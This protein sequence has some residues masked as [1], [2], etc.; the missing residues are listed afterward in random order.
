MCLLCGC[1]LSQLTEAEMLARW[2]ERDDREEEAELKKKEAAEEAV[3]QKEKQRKA[4]NAAR[5]KANRQKKKGGPAPPIAE[6]LRPAEAPT[7]VPPP[8]PIYWRPR[9][10]TESPLQSY[11]QLQDRWKPIRAKALED[12]LALAESPLFPLWFSPDVPLAGPAPPTAEV[13]SPAVSK[14]GDEFDRE[15]AL[16]MEVSQ[17]DVSTPAEVASEDRAKVLSDFYFA[18]DTRAYAVSSS[19]EDEEMLPCGQTKTW[20]E[21]ESATWGE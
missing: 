20:V 10:P 13:L 12:L 21:Q 18:A 7:P 17:V 6:V 3:Q 8:T 1:G 2:A 11:V 15:L 5:V 14:L 4:V 16:A 9:T 19:D